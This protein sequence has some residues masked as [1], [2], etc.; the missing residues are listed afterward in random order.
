LRDRNG[1]LT[2]A[3]FTLHEPRVALEGAASAHQQY[4]DTA[5]VKIGEMLALSGFTYVYF[6]ETY[7]SAVPFSARQ[8]DGSIAYCTPQTT[9]QILD[10]AISRFDSALGMTGDPSIVRLGGVGAGGG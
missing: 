1:T 5:K 2:A 6:A 10:R 7:C 4:V 8:S 3:H 9:T